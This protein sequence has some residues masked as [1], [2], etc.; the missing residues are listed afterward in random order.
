MY[1]ILFRALAAPG[2][3]ETMVK[4]LKNNGDVSTRRETGTLRFDVLEDPESDSVFVYEAYRNKAAF[5]AHK[6]GDLFQEWELKIKPTLK[7]FEIL[8]EG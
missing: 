1:T 8:Y 6:K 2:G 5:E 4:S 3:K 7:N